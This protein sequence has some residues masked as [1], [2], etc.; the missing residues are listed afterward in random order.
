MHIL[1]CQVLAPGESPSLGP[2]P[3]AQQICTLKRSP[4]PAWLGWEHTS[5]QKWI[6]SHPDHKLR[7]DRT[8]QRRPGSGALRG[9]PPLWSGSIRH[10][11]TGI[12]WKVLTPMGKFWGSA[13]LSLSSHQ[14]LSQKY[15]HCEMRGI[16]V[17]SSPRHVFTPGSSAP[18]LRSH[19]ASL[20]L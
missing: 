19:S 14:G 5:R 15:H 2:Q 6:N 7:P 20:G 12:F 17:G 18:G 11:T 4:S 10:R 3:S 1:P 16:G 13:V 8:V 9:C